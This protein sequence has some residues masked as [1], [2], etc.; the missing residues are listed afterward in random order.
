MMKIGKRKRP[1]CGSALAAD[2]DAQSL[3][4]GPESFDA[5]Q[6]DWISCREA[7]ESPIVNGDAEFSCQARVVQDPVEFGS[8]VQKLGQVLARVMRLGVLGVGVDAKFIGATA[9]EIEKVKIRRRRNC[10]DDASV[11]ILL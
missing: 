7:A 4:F 6:S 2:G 5:G 11:E 9:R 8:L 1:L 3:E 10:C